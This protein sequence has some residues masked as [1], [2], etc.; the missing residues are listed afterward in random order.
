[1]LKIATDPYKYGVKEWQA[2]RESNPDLWY[3]NRWL[4]HQLRCFGAGFTKCLPTF[5]TCDAYQ[6]KKPDNFG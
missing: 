1:M 4:V 3:R 2:R 5:V 6:E